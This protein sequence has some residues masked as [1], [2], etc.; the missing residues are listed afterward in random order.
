MIMD[1]DI[2]AMKK[3]IEENFESLSK[4]LKSDYDRICVIF[5]ETLT[6]IYREDLAKESLHL[7]M[8]ISFI[9]SCILL[10]LDPVKEITEMSNEN[11]DTLKNEIEI[12]R[13]E[14]MEKLNAKN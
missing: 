10:N 14:F 3:L 12:L 6:K 8:A 5:Q 4:K 2:E 13:K 1:L 11:L 7:F 9:K